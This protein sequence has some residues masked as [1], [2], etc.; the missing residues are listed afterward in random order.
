MARW[1]NENVDDLDL[2]APETI[3]TNFVGTNGKTVTEKKAFAKTV[4]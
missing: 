4:T 3:V 1:D 2:P